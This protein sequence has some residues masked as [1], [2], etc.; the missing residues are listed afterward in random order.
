MMRGWSDGTLKKFAD[1]SD[2]LLNLI[3]FLLNP[4]F[5]CNL[6]TVTTI[7]IAHRSCELWTKEHDKGW[8]SSNA[9][10]YHQQ[11]KDEA[12]WNEV[13]TIT[14]GCRWTF[15][16]QFETNLVSSEINVAISAVCTQNYQRVSKVLI[17]WFSRFETVE[18][19][20]QSDLIYCTYLLII[21]Q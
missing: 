8:V 21:V 7:K 5:L 14:I 13:A 3:E 15:E 20:K 11:Q 17:E 9:L 10:L 18:K 1:D 6:L 19:R 16:L 4:E 2:P 12:V